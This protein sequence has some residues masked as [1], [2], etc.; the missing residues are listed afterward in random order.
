MRR[1]IVALLA[2]ALA[3]PVAAQVTPLPTL[4]A[5]E[6][7]DAWNKPTPKPDAPPSTRGT[8]A[9][10]KGATSD[11]KRKELNSKVRDAVK[12]N[13]EKAFDELSADEAKHK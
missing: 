8:A 1:L 11:A 2:G 7:R 3:A 9:R 4:G 10:S 5:V 6:R 13:A 12:A